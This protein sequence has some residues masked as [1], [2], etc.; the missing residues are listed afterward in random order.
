MK[1]YSIDNFFT[2]SLNAAG[3]K[4]PLTLPDG[5]ETGEYLVVMGYH[6]DEAVECR[7]AGRLASEQ[8]DHDLKDFDEGSKEYVNLQEYGLTEIHTSLARELVFDWSF[9]DF[10]QDTLD[11]LLAENKG[12]LPFAITAHAA[13]AENFLKK[14]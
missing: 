11:R 2:Q 12:T 5:T 8:L 6:A 1:K 13:N 7:E 14:K 3:S 4:L 9:G 10:D